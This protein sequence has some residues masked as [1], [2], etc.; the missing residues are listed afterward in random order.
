M[1]VYEII[2]TGILVQRYESISKAFHGECGPTDSV[3]CLRALL[4]SEFG[5]SM[6]TG[7]HIGQNG[8]VIDIVVA[9]NLT[10]VIAVKFNNLGKIVIH[11]IKG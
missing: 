11:R 6:L 7:Y 5:K 2:L 9:G 10:G 4:Y 1:S 3:G 8:L